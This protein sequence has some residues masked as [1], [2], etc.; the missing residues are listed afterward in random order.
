MEERVLVGTIGVDAG[1]CWVG[2]PCYIL[3]ADKLPEDIG[4]NWMDFCDKIEGVDYPTLKQFNYD[5][6]HPGLGVCVSTGFGDGEYPV[7][8][9]V[10]DEGVWGKRVKSITVEFISEEEDDNGD[11]ISKD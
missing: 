11:R 9:I 5:L 4:K 3:H 1:L 2:D 7:Y 10:S 8:A 6:G